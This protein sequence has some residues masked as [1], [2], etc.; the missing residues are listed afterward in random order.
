MMND[1]GYWIIITMFFSRLIGILEWFVVL[2]LLMEVILCKDARTVNTVRIMNTAAAVRLR[3]FKTSW[4]SLFYRGTFI[5]FFCALFSM[6]SM[7][8]DLWLGHMPRAPYTWTMV[9]LFLPVGIYCIYKNM[10]YQITLFTK[11]NL[12]I[13]DQHD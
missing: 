2:L 5:L 11:F 10:G 1:L 7:V 8:S 9:S 4:K 12:F 3:M 13:K 6:V